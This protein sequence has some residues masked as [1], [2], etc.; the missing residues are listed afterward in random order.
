MIDAELLALLRECDAIG[1][2]VAASHGR[3]APRGV[4]ASYARRVIAMRRS[5]LD[6]ALRGTR[7]SPPQPLPAAPLAEGRWLR[8]VA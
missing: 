3:G 4:T 8:L 2:L 6:D 1:E 5:L 7:V